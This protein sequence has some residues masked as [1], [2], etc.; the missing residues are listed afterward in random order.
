MCHYAV[1]MEYLYFCIY[2]IYSMSFFAFPLNLI[3]A[4]LWIIAV[5]MSF[6][7]ARDSKAVRFMLSPAATLTAIGL[8]SLACL[9]IGL[10][11]NR[12]WVRS[13]PFIIIYLFLMTVLLYVVIR[14]WKT[15][16]IVRWRFLLN[17]AGLL[18][19]MS[20]AFFGAPDSEEL[21]L[22]VF[23][24]MPAR[25]AFRTDGARAW[26]S[27]EVELKDFRIETYNDGTPSSYEADVIVAGNPVTLK[28]NHPYSIGLAEDVY[29]SSY[30]SVSGEY[31]I[32]QVVREPW[33]YPALGGIIM[34]LSGA[35]LLFIQG[36]RK[37]K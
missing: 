19:A 8:F 32:L 22:Q 26:L 13:V 23:K 5:V 1:F 10:T 2:R 18:L 4:L 28:V 17:H 31:C 6:R 25:E 9:I 20:S 21:R 29:L 16:N 37:K 11:G 24:D 12:E 34:L 15:G 36:P 35:L 7:H 3:S 33:K 14:G 30:D 27:Y